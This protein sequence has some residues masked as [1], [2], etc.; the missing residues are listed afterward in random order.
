MNRH[1]FD[2]MGGI[3]VTP[4]STL[5]IF[6]FIYDTADEAQVRAAEEGCAALMK[7]AAA[8]GYGDYRSHLSH[9]DHVAGLYDFNDG[10]VMRLNTR[11]KD[12]L[13]PNGILAPG[14]QGSWPSAMKERGGR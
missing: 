10:A 14:K 3:I 11:L 9:M 7:A 8:A 5:Q 1:G 13:D 4:C 2:Y 6:E 12:T